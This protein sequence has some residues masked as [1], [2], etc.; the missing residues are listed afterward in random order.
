[1]KATASLAAS[2]A[3][4]AAALLA[5]SAQGEVAHQWSST[6]NV[7]EQPVS[8]AVDESNGSVY[9]LTTTTPNANAGKLYKFDSTGAPSNFSALGTNVL[10]TGCTVECRQVAVDNSGG[11]NQSV[12]YVSTQLTAEATKGV[13]VYYPNGRAGTSLVTPPEYISSGYCGVGVDDTGVVVVSRSGNNSNLNNIGNAFNTFKPGQI[14]PDPFPAQVWAPQAT[15]ANVGNPNPCRLAADSKNQVY[16]TPDSASAANQFLER[17][18][19]RYKIDPFANS[20]PAGRLIDTGSTGLAI[21][22]SGD[23]LYSNHKTAI[24]RFNDEGELLETFSGGGKLVESGAVAVNGTSGLVHAANRLENKIQVFTTVV[25]PDVDSLESV[26]AQTTA[27]LSASVGTAGVGDVTDC[28]FEYGTTTAYGTTADCAEALPYG[29]DEDVSASIAGLAKETTYHWRLAVTNANGVTRSPDRTF[30]TH[31]VKGVSTDLPDDI[32]QTS[33]TLKGSF[34]GNGEATS[35]HFEW[36]ETSLYGNETP[37]EPAGSPTGPA[38]VSAPIA[39]LDVYLPESDPYHFRLV[40]T[41]ASGTTY[42][43]DRTF[44][45]APPNAPAISAVQTGEAAP[46]VAP[47][48]ALINPEGGPTV[49]WIEY[50]PG[51]NYGTATLAGTS[52]GEDTVDHLVEPELTGLNPGSTYHYRIVASNFGGITT[53]PDQSFNT[54]NVPILGPIS[55]ASVTETS[56]SVQGFVNPGFSP[57][58]YRFEYGLTRSYEASTA[59]TPVPVSDNTEQQVG[60]TIAGLKAGITY[61]Y[62]LVATNGEGT[63]ES[64]DQTFTTVSPPVPKQ[65]KP[66]PPPPTLKCKKGFVKKNGKCKK[67]PKKHKHKKHKKKGKKKNKSCKGASK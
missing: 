15:I 53:S 35:Y 48:S 64:A 56:A 52:I 60:A 47:I 54:P 16:V 13:R 3:A 51:S 10:T 34:V 33:A 28:E 9:V 55:T 17:E 5:P 40:A 44:F 23:E 36:G 25:T 22:Q 2:I 20:Q 8:M 32:T 12:V 24:A 59:Q 50:G 37:V 61:H 14:L 31:N 26:A 6:F 38:S 58:S 65:A 27:S 1:V 29:G 18:I 7:A 63:V 62:R 42:G 67:K 45:S 11:I 57:T 49:Y 30:T 46:T 66:T 41:N 4:L 39:G 19:V 21:D 43:P